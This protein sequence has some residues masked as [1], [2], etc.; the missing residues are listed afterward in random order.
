LTLRPE[1]S[2]R[3]ARAGDAAEMARVHVQA[4]RDAYAG[5]VPDAVLAGLSVEKRTAGWREWL[6]PDQT[7]RAALAEAGRI[8]AQSESWVAEIEGAIVAFAG[9]GASRDPDAS[10][11]GE[12]FSI[13]AIER[14]WDRGVGRALLARANAWMSELSFADATLWVLE[15]NTR[16]RRFY[17]ADGW[18]PDGQRKLLD[19]AGT[20]LYEV[21]YRK[22]LL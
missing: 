10:N 6:E 3:V 22:L 2:V 13:Y 7:Q 21:R 4:W 16:A 9:A 11:T 1:A 15:G 18:S 8:V 14:A 5:L 20:E 17:E 12:L 19:F